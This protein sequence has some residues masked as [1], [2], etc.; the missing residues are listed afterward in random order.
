MSLLTP[1]PQTSDTTSRL[2]VLRHAM[3]SQVLV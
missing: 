1:P 2:C 3:L